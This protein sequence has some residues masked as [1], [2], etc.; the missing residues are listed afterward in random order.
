MSDGIS[1]RDFLRR[2]PRAD[3]PPPKRVLPKRVR[4][5]GAV[6]EADFLARCT[7]CME[8]VT[9]CPTNAIHTLAEHVQP[10]P[11]TPVMVLDARPCA[12]CEGFPCVAAC[13]EQALLMPPT[14]AVRLA[15][16]DIDATRC[17]PYRGPECGA[18]V[19]LCPA[20]AEGGLV[21][22]RG[23][24]VVDREICVGCG[25]CI[26]ACVVSPAAISLV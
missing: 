26:A 9:A 14:P 18:C 25:L 7:A 22:M 23:R 5:P 13:P 10:G 20:G 3:S 4:P 2:R 6:A 19:G 1:R 17:L 24:P 15:L 12:M 16:V 8:C 11:G 21:L